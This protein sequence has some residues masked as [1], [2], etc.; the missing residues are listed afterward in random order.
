V[1]VPV[2]VALFTAVRS[3]V[4]VVAQPLRGII[5]S[6]VAQWPQ[7]N[8]AALVPAMARY[9]YIPAGTRCGG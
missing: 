1:V 3:P 9:A 8:L 5:S 6:P 4:W 7:V 2:T